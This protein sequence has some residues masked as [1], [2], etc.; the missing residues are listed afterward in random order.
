MYVSFR[1]V[2]FYVHVQRFP[3][4]P[5]FTLKKM[6][7]LSVSQPNWFYVGFE[8]TIIRNTCNVSAIVGLRV[9]KW[10]LTEV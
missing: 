4:N 9:F 2:S 3:E 8:V 1:A 7:A 6:L 5:T 10:S